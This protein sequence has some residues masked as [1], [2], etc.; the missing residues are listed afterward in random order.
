MISGHCIPK[1]NQWLNNLYKNFKL[2]NIAGVYGKQEPLDTSDPNDIRDLNIFC[3]KIQIKD[4]FF[5]N[6]NSMIDKN[7]GKN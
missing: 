2:K 3:I 4:P 1:H 7:F 5:H 6:A